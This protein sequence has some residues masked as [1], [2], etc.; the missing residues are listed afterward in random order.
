MGKRE[1]VRNS[2]RTMSESEAKVTSTR[3]GIPTIFSLLTE[4]GTQTKTH[5]A[6]VYIPLST[7]TTLSL[8]LF[9]HLEIFTSKQSRLTL[10]CRPF[11]FIKP[12][13]EQGT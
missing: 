11:K 5:I 6:R 12:E 8:K 3:P 2:K 1:K 4:R 9:V 13:V 7:P 10:K